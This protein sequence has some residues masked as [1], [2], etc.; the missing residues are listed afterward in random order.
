M[1]NY[2]NMQKENQSLCVLAST[3]LAKLEDL[4]HQDWQHND[5]ILCDY[6]TAFRLAS[7]EAFELHEMRSHIDRNSHAEAYDIEDSL[8]NGLFNKKQIEMIKKIEKDRFYLTSAA[9]STGDLKKVAKRVHGYI[10]ALED[11]IHKFR[12]E[13]RDY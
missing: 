5:H 7:Q 4:D 8:D 13:Y 2:V 10:P 11:M 9:H 1:G 3:D 6:L 12:F